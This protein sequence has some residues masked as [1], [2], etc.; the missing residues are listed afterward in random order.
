MSHKLLQSARGTSTGTVLLLT[1]FLVSGATTALAADSPPAITSSL[2]ATGAVN[3][4]FSYTITASGTGPVSFSAA[5]LPDG[6]TLSG[7]S[8]SG[9]PTDAGTTSVTLGAVNAAG[10]DSKTLVITINPAGAPGIT[11]A[12]TATGNVGSAFSYQITASGNTPVALDATNLP[13]GLSLAGDT[14]SGTPTTTGVANVTLTATNALGTDTKLL[15][16]TINPA[17]APTITS[18]LTATGQATQTFSY[19]I[20][21]S[22]TG[23]T[24]AATGTPAWLTL[25]GAGLSGTPDAPGNYAIQLTATNASGSDAKTLRLTVTPANSSP[26]VV[27]DISVSRNP[28]RTDTNVTF[29]VQA[30]SLSG[31]PL[32]YSW[33]FF[34]NQVKDGPVLSSQAVTRQFPLE[35][36]YAVVVVAS[37][38]YSTSAQFRKVTI[39][40][41]PNPGGEGQNITDGQPELVNPESGLGIK[42]TGSLAGVLDVDVVPGAP[43]ADEA[44]ET[45]FSNGRSAASGMYVASKFQQSH[46]YVAT[47]TAKQNGVTTRK[48]RKMLPVAKRETGE[49]QS[50][51]VE[52][53]SRAIGEIKLKGKCTFGQKSDKIIMTGSVELPAGMDLSQSVDVPVGVGNIVDTVR[54]TNKGKMISSAQALV[55]KMQIRFPRLPKG[56]T[57]TKAGDKAKLS[58][59]ISGSRL[60][61]LGLDTEGITNS[62]DLTAKQK[63][64]RT[65]QTA[66][67]LGGVSYETLV[68]V[69]YMYA[70]TSGGTFMSRRQ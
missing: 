27:T 17:G 67:V 66:V 57:T 11:S 7:S 45:D 10:S 49:A 28:V 20:A 44:Y 35:G 40:L 62:R 55:T 70:E 26:P 32:S 38:G 30:V 31:L 12:L 22:G 15:E 47:A 39:T 34:L 43:R 3:A 29:S 51:T 6:I 42:V 14:I 41:A 19:T 8:L 50:G 18:P 60:H 58:I 36:D 68:N 21:A 69:D 54:L 52:P 4:A 33:Y 48:M 64:A 37:D 53:G 2:A 65:V 16:V 23:V 5:P 46:I 25:A 24:Y 13:A 61:D 9:T 1:V 56:V 59:T 63:Y